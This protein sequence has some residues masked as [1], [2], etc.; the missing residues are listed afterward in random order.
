MS[1]RKE[2]NSIQGMKDRIEECRQELLNLLSD[3]H[4]LKNIVQPQ[5]MFT[6]D[7]IF[8]DLEVE[9]NNKSFIASELDR[10]V[11]VLSS[12][13]RRGEKLTEKTI[14][15]LNMYVGRNVNNT[16]DENISNYEKI[17][18]NYKVGYNFDG[19][20][21]NNNY[22][23]PQ[24]YRQIVKKL[25]PDV[26]GDTENFQKFWDNIQDAY[27]SRDVKRLRLFHQTLCKDIDYGF[28][29]IRAEENALKMEIKDLE[30]NIFSEKV[31]ITQIKNQEPYN[32]QDKLNDDLW[33]SKRKRQLREQIFSIDRKIQRQRR[34]LI[35]MTKDH[36]PIQIARSIWEVKD[37]GFA[38]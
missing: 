18:N 33:V 2:N 7:S 5:L 16:I 10:R 17:T 34:L 23:I 36:L 37:Y 22:E 12:K 4:L 25:H 9:L 31:K 19:F 11:E 21:I 15:F 38:S 8:G 35:S 28:S 26:N 13:I 30:K 29:D 32:F 14:N 3:W 6:Y 27:K 20:E 24:L 1:I